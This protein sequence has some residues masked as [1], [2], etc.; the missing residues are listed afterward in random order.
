MSAP[1]DREKKDLQTSLVSDGKES[2]CSAGD[3]G[4]RPRL[5]RFPGEGNGYALV[6]LPGEC[7]GQRSLADSV[8]GVT[9]SWTGLSN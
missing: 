6:F 9:K 1:G 4:W 2:A 5:G 8:H 7:H 3:L